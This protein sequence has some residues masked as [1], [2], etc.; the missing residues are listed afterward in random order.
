MKERMPHY[1][2]LAFSQLALT[3][4]LTVL[5]LLQV[6]LS[7]HTLV[8]VAAVSCALTVLVPYTASQYTSPGTIL[9]GSSRARK[10][11]LIDFAILAFIQAVFA[12]SVAYSLTQSADDS[13]Y[14]A[15]V[16]VISCLLSALCWSTLVAATRDLDSSIT[17]WY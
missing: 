15:G 2:L 1:K 10:A 17:G 14:R 3:I 13:P 6:S 16:S 4:G 11:C 9:G 5:G 8:I 12:I 7:V